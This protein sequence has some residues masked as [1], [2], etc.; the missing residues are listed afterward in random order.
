MW[1]GAS[2]KNPEAKQVDRVGLCLAFDCYYSGFGVSLEP[3]HP[4]NQKREIIRCEIK[5]GLFPDAF[6]VFEK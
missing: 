1:L 6:R 5:V 2:L 3:E 4:R